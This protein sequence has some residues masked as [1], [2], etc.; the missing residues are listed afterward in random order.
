MDLAVEPRQFG[1]F[2]PER[3]GV[4]QRFAPNG[5]DFHFLTRLPVHHGGGAIGSH[6]T[7]ALDLEICVAGIDGVSDGSGDANNF[8]HQS[9][10]SSQLARVAEDEVGGH[11]PG[12]DSE[13]IEGD[14]PNQ[15]APTFGGEIFHQVGFDP[16]GLERLDEGPGA[17]CGGALKLAKG[18][19]P[20]S[21]VID[22]G[23]GAAGQTDKAE[24]AEDPLGSEV[25]G[26]KFLAAQA[27][28]EREDGGLRAEKRGE[29]FG[30]MGT[31]RGFYGHD[32]Q[33]D[34]ADFGRRLKNIRLVNPSAPDP[35]PDHVH[36]HVYI[37]CCGQHPTILL[38]GDSSDQGVGR[39]PIGAFGEE[40]TAINVKGKG[41]TPFVRSA[42]EVQSSESDAALPHVE[43]E[44]G[45]IKQLDGDFIKRLSSI[46]FG[47]QR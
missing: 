31:G 46:P 18:K 38:V 23:R 36:V 45:F 28:L 44:R 9:P 42:I 20:V 2:D 7:G 25:L 32:D 26:Q 41:M 40:G 33:I 11:P 14:V 15:F 3:A 13:S 1:H 30:E 8:F 27:I 35:D 43:R 47:H 24:S 4:P 12:G 34:R 16:T 21:C 17:G 5:L 10:A 22:A 37:R 29:E 39:N 19:R 6:R